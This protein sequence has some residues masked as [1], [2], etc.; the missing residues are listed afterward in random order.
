MAK[1]TQL[2]IASTPDGS[3]LVPV[4]QGEE[5]R[6]TTLAEIVEVA[7]QPYVDAA[8]AAASFAESVVGPDYGSIA[9]G[10]AATVSGQGFAV[11]NGDGTVTTY[12]N[13]GGSATVQRTLGTTAYFANSAGASRVGFLHTGAGAVARNVQDKLRELRSVADYVTHAAA[14]A[15]AVAAGVALSVATPVTSALANKGQVSALHRGDAQVTL[16]DG[17]KLGKQFSRVTAQPSSITSW[18]SA[19]T[20]FNGDLRYSLFQHEHHID[21][22][23]LPLPTTGYLYCQPAAG[24]AAY[25]T[26]RGGGNHATGGND[27]RTS[28]NYLFIKVDNY[29]GGDAA[30]I[31]VSG[32]CVGAGPAG[33]T[34]WL[35]MPAT[36]ALNGT[37]TMGGHARYANFIEC[38]LQLQSFDAAAIGMVSN[39]NRSIGDTV[40]GL[41]SLTSGFRTQSKGSY[42]IDSAFSATGLCKTMIDGTPITLTAAKAFMTMTAGSRIYGNAL[43]TD[44]FKATSYGTDWLERSTSG[45]W[46]FVY[47]N[48]SCL[49]VNDSVVCALVALRLDTRVAANVPAAG[50]YLRGAEFY[51]SDASSLTPRSAYVGGGINFAKIYCDGSAWRIAV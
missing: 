12:R 5:M 14:Q 26:N 21:A 46:H 48:T 42:A 41:G 51:V 34:S 36:V 44:G 20:A 27:G 47:N 7:A 43:S 11:G 40:N 4:V 13:E 10:L 49:Q 50:S 15:A 38:D 28:A 39:I 25:F 45:F 1:I 32:F 16:A 6:V 37:H 8:E 18:D 3:E 30:G 23:A 17:N 24:F 9:A 19:D 29:G 33:A 31:T 35:A 2:P 22:G